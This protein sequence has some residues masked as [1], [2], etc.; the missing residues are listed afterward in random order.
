MMT[1][2]ADL[3]LKLSP[4]V[5]FVKLETAHS[6]TL[7]G[8]LLKSNDFNQKGEQLYLKLS[9]GDSLSLQIFK[10]QSPHVVVLFHG[11]GGD[12]KSDYM[13]RSAQVAFD[14]GHSVVLVDHRG[15]GLAAGLAQKPYHSG[16]GEDAAVVSLKLRELFPEKKQIFIGFSMSG[17]ILLNLVT[18][19]RGDQLPDYCV[20]VNAPINL[21][22]S[23]KLL[24]SGFS[25]IY[26]IRFY[27]MLRK[28]IFANDQSIRLPSWGTTQLIDELYTSKKSG[29]KDS[30]D[31]Y[32][33]CSTQLF[34]N[35]IATPTFVL[36]SKDDPFIAFEDYKTAKW[37]RLAHTTF[38]DHGGH[39]GYISKVKSV[40]FG[41]RWLDDY[42]Y[43][44]LML[45]GNMESA[46]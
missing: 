36:T 17:S 23:S 43:K 15:A 18:Q 7:L 40:R 29:F 33:Q 41:S 32:T 27:Q 31:Y 5:P 8:H 11:L 25:K 4:F 38:V 28:L 3:D 42:L 21:S 13:Q 45:I 46:I 6:Q 24:M 10:N 14:L 44:V 35:Q 16:R 19:R 2:I 1:E 9:D 30:H 37:N 34:V 22:K 39:M 12:S 20:V 26:D